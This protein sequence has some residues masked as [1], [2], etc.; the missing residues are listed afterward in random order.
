MEDDG[1]LDQYERPNSRGDRDAALLRTLRVLN[2]GERSSTSAS[3]T[4]QSA[5]GSAPP[6]PEK[7]LRFVT[8]EQE[9]MTPLGM[10]Q[11]Q[12]RNHMEG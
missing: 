2:H 5:H 12:V 1:E 9:G 3:A 7:I 4:S 8:Q 10:L 6:A 11:M